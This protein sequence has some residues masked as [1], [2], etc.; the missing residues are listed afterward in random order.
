MS[1]R[2]GR[3]GNNLSHS[4]DSPVLILF[5]LLLVLINVELTC[6][7]QNFWVLLF[8]VSYKILLNYN[9]FISILFNMPVVKDLMLIHDLFILMLFSL[10]FE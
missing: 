3:R 9:W 4:F 10:Y 8:N 1:Q 2:L 5:N 6:L 7:L